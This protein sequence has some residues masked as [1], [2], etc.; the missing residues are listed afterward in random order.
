MLRYQFLVALGAVAVL[1]LSADRLWAQQGGGTGSP[2]ANV[3]K[4]TGMAS[5]ESEAEKKPGGKA[6]SGQR[7]DSKKHR[8]GSDK[9]EGAAG[10]KATPGQQ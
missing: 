9:V 6:L 8:P 7:P 1:G 3:P 4:E 10:G 5:K 2:S